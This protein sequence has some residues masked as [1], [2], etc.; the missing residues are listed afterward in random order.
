MVQSST[1]RISSSRVPARLIVSIDSNGRIPKECDAL[2]WASV[3]LASRGA[4]VERT[5]P[6]CRG[7]YEE[8][9]LF[10]RNWDCC[11]EWE[12]NGQTAEVHS[13]LQILSKF[14]FCYFF[15]ILVFTQCA[16]KNSIKGHS[17]SVS[18]FLKFLCGWAET[19]HRYECREDSMTL[20]SLKVHQL[21]FMPWKLLQGHIASWFQVVGRIEAYKV[22]K[23]LV[24]GYS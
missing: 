15:S 17:F 22:T 14:V 24:W 13:A 4:R 21:K 6:K 20:I 7:C 16:L 11:D 23:N 2:I 10:P 9:L 5:H 1:K 12:V 8:S 18:F 3:T 19:S